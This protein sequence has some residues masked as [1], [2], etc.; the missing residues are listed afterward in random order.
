MC[1]SMAELAPRFSSNRMLRQYV[2]EMYLPAAADYRS[3][4]AEEARI[5]R[6]LAVWEARLLYHWSDIAFVFVDARA[7]HGMLHVVTE[8][9]LGRLQPDEVRVELC[10]DA[11]GDEPVARVPMCCEGPAPGRL[12]AFRFT[13]T[14]ATRRPAAHFTP[15][16]VPHHPHARV[17]LELPL[18]CW[19]E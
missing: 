4:A 13:A 14:V 2:E 16:V 18:I 6:E 5:A 11:D 3:R 9:A 15:R 17:P 10:A 8:V 7:E 1:A 19:P 12:A